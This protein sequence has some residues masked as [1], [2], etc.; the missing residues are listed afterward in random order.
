MSKV[1]TPMLAVTAVILAY[2]WA[3]VI[4]PVIVIGLIRNPGPT[5]ML[6]IGLIAVTLG[7]VVVAPGLVKFVSRTQRAWAK[8]VF[9]VWKLIETKRT[10]SRAEKDIQSTV[11]TRDDLGG[12][13]NAD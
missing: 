8:L 3:V 6:A 9:E 13:P 4:V 12:D 2:P 10:I 7:L 5:S 1:T 11:L